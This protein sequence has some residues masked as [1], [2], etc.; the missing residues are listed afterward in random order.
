[1]PTL[2]TV[3]RCKEFVLRKRRLFSGAADGA[4]TFTPLSQNSVL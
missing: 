4:M 3:A 2:F 1:M